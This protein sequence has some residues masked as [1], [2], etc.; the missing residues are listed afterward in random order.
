M[1]S[2]IPSKDTPLSKVNGLPTSGWGPFRYEWYSICSGHYRFD[3]ECPR[4]LAGRWIN[5]WMQVV[6]HQIH[7]RAY[8]VWFWW[9]N[10]KWRK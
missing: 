9:A 4:C 6:E 1:P 8:P 7:D 2:F 3:V 5:C 10:R